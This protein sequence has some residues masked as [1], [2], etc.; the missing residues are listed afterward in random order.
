MKHL[1]EEIHR[2]IENNK[3]V[4]RDVARKVGVDP[5]YLG[6]LRYR[7]SFD[8]ALLEK[9]SKILNVPLGYFFDD[10]ISSAPLCGDVHSQSVMGDAHVNIGENYRYMQELLR[11][12][13]NI[14][15]EKQKMIDEKERL[16]SILLDRLDACSG[17]KS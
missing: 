11:M 12:K 6:Q 14:I 16:I 3:L 15:D 9:F 1:G 13:Q 4:K 17:V 10:Y 5:S 7:A 8:A 2:I